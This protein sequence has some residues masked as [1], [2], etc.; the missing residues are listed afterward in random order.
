MSA[1][2]FRCFL[3]LL[4]P[5]HCCVCGERLSAEEEL[6]C[7]RCNMHIPRTDHY[8]SPE[9]NP[10]AQMFWGRVKAVD[11]AGAWIEHHSGQQSS[12]PIYQIKYY[13][14][15]EV[16]VDLGEL[17]GKDMLWA[18]FLEGVEAIVPI[19]LDKRRTAER[20]YNQSACIAKG[21]ACATGL[22]VVD[23]V[24]VRTS[25]KASQTKMERWGRYDNVKDA[26]SVVRGERLSG[27]RIL[28]LDDVVTTGATL[29]AAAKTLE[30]ID[31][32]KITAA[33]VGI[34]EQ[35]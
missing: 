9:D 8:A 23:N 30:Q 6:I 5:R 29:C 31:G 28:L 18:N 21:V 14:R 32:L 7:L 25:F 13:E 34:A 2:L 24:L 16:G 17:M 10:M 1:S 33:A 26:F 35:R 11:R 15:P 4:S 22:K 3:D 20:G 12:F 27:K 19:P